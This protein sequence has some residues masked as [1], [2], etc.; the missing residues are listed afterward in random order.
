MFGDANGASEY[1]YATGD[2]TGLIMKTERFKGKSWTATFTGPDGKVY[3]KYEPRFFRLDGAEVKQADLTDGF[4]YFCTYDV[5]VE[6]MVID[7]SANAFP[8]TYYITGDTFA[9]NEN[10]G[11]DEFFQFIIPKAK[12]TSENTITLEAEGD[13]SVFNMSLK[14]LRPADGVMMKLVKYNL[15]DGDDN[16]A[17]A[18]TLYH[19]HNLD[20]GK[21]TSISGPGVVTVSEDKYQLACEGATSW[22]SSDSNVAEVTAKGEVTAKAEGAVI[23]TATDDDDNAYYHT[24]I[25][26]AAKA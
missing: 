23:I 15:I 24:I 9:R 4:D 17:T 12:V 6:G 8:G 2:A 14:V 7:I 1:N 13:P 22:T 3:E 10:S 16:A 26:K 11:K 25:V 21:V 20:E 19:N 18:S 5:K